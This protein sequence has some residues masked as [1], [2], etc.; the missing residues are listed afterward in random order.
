MWWSAVKG[1]ALAQEVTHA[2]E[3][4]VWDMRMV[5]DA[6]DV[7][8]DLGEWILDL[9]ILDSIETGSEATRTSGTATI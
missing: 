7:G 6:V 8:A 1:V 4:I 9:V 5:V 2:D 3:P